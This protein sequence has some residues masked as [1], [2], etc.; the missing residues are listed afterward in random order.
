MLL[1]LGHV[2]A[3]EE[4]VGLLLKRLAARSFSKEENAF[5]PLLTRRR[6]LEQEPDLLLASAY[7][8]QNC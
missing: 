1:T 3:G 6:P 5:P 8:L 7:M 4:K 2:S